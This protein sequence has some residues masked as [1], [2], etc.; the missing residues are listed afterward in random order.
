MDVDES[1]MKRAFELFD[2]D[3]DGKI[4]E[5]ELANVMSVLGKPMSKA[6]LK[7]MI[8]GAV[9]GQYTARGAAIDFEAFQQMV[10]RAAALRPRA[11][12]AVRVVKSPGVQSGVSAS[13][14][15]PF[16]FFGARRAA[17]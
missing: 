3:G 15:R 7:G 16:I 12:A 2:K 10:V 5:E 6:E 8:G 14:S 1:K 17:K 11:C 9:D 4:S 13:A